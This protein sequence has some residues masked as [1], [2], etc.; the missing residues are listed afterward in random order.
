MAFK[1]MLAVVAAIAMAFLPMLAAQTVHPV[2][3]ARG[4]RLGVDYTTWSEGNQ[5]NTNET[6]LFGYNQAFHNVL[7]VSGEDFEACNTANPIATWSSGSDEV[8]LEEAGK[9][10][11]ICGVGKHCLL[12][13]KLNVT[14]FAADA[15]TSAPAPA[16]GPWTAPAPYHESRRPFV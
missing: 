4:W 10:W 12:G 11:F 14:I 16:P 13:M 7:E 15:G 1:Q 5:F 9:R 3:D 8:E 6:L 2:G